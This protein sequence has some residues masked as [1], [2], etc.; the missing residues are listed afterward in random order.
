[1][2]SKLPKFLWAKGWMHSVW[3]RNR[4]PMAALPN[5]KTPMEMATKRKPNLS[6]LLEWGR[7]IWLKVKNAGTL[8][9][10]AISVNF[11][12]YDVEAKGFR[13]YWLGKRKVT[14]ER[15]VYFKKNEALE[16]E[17]TSIEGEWEDDD[18]LTIP[19]APSM[20][21]TPPKGDAMMGNNQKEGL[22]DTIEP[23]IPDNLRKS[24]S[25]EPNPTPAET[26]ST[27]ETP[28]PPPPHACKPQSDGLIV[29]KPNTGRGQCARKPPGF[30]HKLN[31]GKASV[32]ESSTEDVA[33]FFEILEEEEDDDPDL[34]LEA[35]EMLCY[36]QVV[37]F[38]LVTK[39]VPMNL[40]DSI[41]GPDAKHW[42]WG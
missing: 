5:Y 22:T 13:V 1:M 31:E 23:P 41:N 20:P 2:P 30:Y 37:E 4:S 34:Q 32:V 25:P 9:I 17:S 8:E 39:S 28:I 36:S 24:P 35:D 38:A 6:K 26:H 29:P 12:G 42:T 3:L 10:H 27:P 7:P 21:Q 19:E 33:A 11:V 14:V 15:D 18:I 40:R 16:P